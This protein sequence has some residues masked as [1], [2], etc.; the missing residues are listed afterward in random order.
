M[1]KEWEIGD[2]A[3]LKNPS[4]Y[5]GYRHVEVVGFDGHKLVVETSSGWQLTVW[6]DELEN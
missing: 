5:K 3:N 2:T 4:H 1:T 6:E